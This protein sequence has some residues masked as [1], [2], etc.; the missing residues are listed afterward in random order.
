MYKNTLADCKN[1]LRRKYKVLRKGISIDLRRKYNGEIFE[2]VIE[3][4]EYKNADTIFSYVSFGDEADTLKIIDHSLKQGK[5]VAVPYCIPHTGFM[6]FY[7]INSLDEL[8][9]GAFGVFEPVPVHSV[10]V[11]VKQGIMIVPGLAFDRKGYRMGYGKGYYDRYLTN[12][13]GVK[14]G[15]CYSCCFRHCVLHNHYDKRVDY[16]ISDNFTKFIAK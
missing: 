7:Y 11:E 10:K 6:D 15:L 2:R 3:C 16:I 14:I 12:F 4:K 8:E 1:Q 5:R 9:K 13:C